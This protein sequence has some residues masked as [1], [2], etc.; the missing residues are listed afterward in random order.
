MC[1][2]TTPT[3]NLLESTN[4]NNAGNQRTKTTDVMKFP[5]INSLS[6][7]SNPWLPNTLVNLKKPL[8]DSPKLTAHAFLNRV[9]HQIINELTAKGINIEHA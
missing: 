3:T 5:I 4:N 9:P 2:Q 8:L 6:T 1:F 7:N